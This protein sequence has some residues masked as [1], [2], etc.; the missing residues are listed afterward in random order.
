MSKSNDR[1]LPRLVIVSG[2]FPD[3]ACGISP[4]VRRIAERTAEPAEFDVH[5]LT[6]ADP[7]VNIN[8]AREYQIHPRIKKWSV[9]Q[10]RRI[11]REILNLAPDIVHIQNPTIKYCSYNSIVM[12]V[13]VPLLKRMAP[14]VRIVV[15]QHDIAVSRRIFRWRYRPMLRAADAIVV[16]NRRDRQAVLDQGIKP[17]NIYLAPFSSFFKLPKRCPE[18]KVAGRQKLS[19][20]TD[21]ICIAYFGFVHPDRNIDTLVQALGLLRK[22]GYNVHGL[23]MGGA[24]AGSREYYQRCRRLADEL[25]L[26]NHITWTGYAKE[27]Q[28]IDGLAGA[29]IFVSLPSRGADLRNTSIITAILAELPIVTTKN[30]RYYHDPDL[31]AMGCIY[32]DARAP[33][34]LARAIIKMIENPPEA[35]FLARSRNELDP[36]RL[37][38]RHIEINLCAYRGE[39]QR[40]LSM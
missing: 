8:L 29:D 1:N 12:S 22:E 20:P 9:F 19:I 17:Q 24:S 10:A 36:E 28:I 26:A 32:A 40:F 13:V 25:S 18:N 30:D 38:Q 33:E 14:A 37:W 6:S 15:M 27:K 16:S 21:S 31:E 23:I 3:I 5:V 35:E 7:T 34:K 39:K 2:S 11:C 4:Y